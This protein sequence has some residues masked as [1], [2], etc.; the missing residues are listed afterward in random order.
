M[1]LLLLVFVS[2]GIFAATNNFLTQTITFPTNVTTSRFASLNNTVVSD[3]L[4]L[5]P[6]E[7]RI[8]IYRQ[9]SSGFTNIP[10]QVIALPQKTAWVAPLDVDANPGLELVLSTANGLFYCR[11]SGGAFET[12]YRALVQNAQVFTNGDLPRLITLT[13][14]DALPII[15][16]DNALLYRRDHQFNWTSSPPVALQFKKT[17]FYKDANDWTMGQDS[18]R[19][20]HVRQSFRSKPRDEENQ[21]PANDGIK[22]LLESI[23][24]ADHSHPPEI[25]R[26]DINGD[27]QPDLIIWQLFPGIET[28]TDVYVFL[29][30][31][32]GK[33][34]EQPNQ[35][36]H[37][38][39]FPIPVR[40][41]HLPI[42]P[43]V[44][45][46]G[47]GAYEVVLLEV[48]TVLAS[49]SGVIDMVLSGALELALTIRPFTRGA[50]PGNPTVAIP[51]RALMPI[52]S[53]APSGAV[54]A[55][56]FMICG[57]FNGD[58][59]PDLL[60]RRSLSH[61]DIYFSTIQGNWFAAQPAMSFESPFEG[62]AEIKDINGDGR[63][64]FTLRESEGNRMAIF[65]SQSPEMK[66]GTP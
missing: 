19:S 54:E 12:E 65:L 52:T 40:T 1:K 36:L 26:A 50:F 20:I 14:N 22:K 5:D 28:R 32:D 4:A 7:K 63:A 49:A 58:G 29:R 60:V 34:P 53:L 46:K 25:R 45:L 62:Q 24:Q 47:D 18:S 31:A 42:T 56:P 13:T 3:L 9:R 41:T 64:D 16:S 66:G 51:I 55:W 59:R 33:L 39:G 27:G 37:C 8:L 48:K 11:Q 6:V 17:S 15:S 10:D 21:K 44:D 38:R 43:V 57:D 35:T 61:W 23:K 30:D 2:P